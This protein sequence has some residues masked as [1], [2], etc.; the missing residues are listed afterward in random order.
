MGLAE[1]IVIL[2][3]IV[4]VSFTHPYCLSMSSDFGDIHAALCHHRVICLLHLILL[5][6][7]I[8]IP[9][10]TCKECVCRVVGSVLILNLSHLIPKTT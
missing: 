9:S 8:Y 2:Y 4:L 3:N 6:Q 10:N 1:Y 5:S 7:I